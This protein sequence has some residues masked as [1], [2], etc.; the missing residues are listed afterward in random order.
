MVI[1]GVDPGKKGGFAVIKGNSVQVFAW[2]D[3]AFV[4]ELRRTVSDSFDDGIVA[5]VEKVG[6]MPGQGVVS[7]F[8][9]GHSAG[10]IEGVL[11]AFNIETV[12]V[13][14][15]KWKKSFDLGSD[16]QKSIEKC[17]ELYPKLSLLP[18]SRCKK[19]SDG[20]AEAILIA[21]YGK[22]EQLDLRSLENVRNEKKKNGGGSNE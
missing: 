11:A 15:Q 20:M 5:Y 22:H 8:H 21:E 7:M 14:P 6:A 16:K 1:I 13:S 4:E 19:P 10:F 9:F 17:Q 12:L 3:N 18:T 2:D